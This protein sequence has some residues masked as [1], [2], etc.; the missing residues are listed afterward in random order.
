MERE[1]L[2]ILRNKIYGLYSRPI[3]ILS[4]AKHIISG[5][6]STIFNIAVQEGGF[7]SKLKPVKVIPVYKSGDETEPGNYRP[8]SLLSIFNRIFEKLLYQRLKNFLDKNDTL[9]KSQYGFREK[10][11]TQHAAIDIVDIIQNNMD[12]KLFTCGIFLDLKKG[13]RYRQSFNLTKKSLIT[14]VSEASLMTGFLRS[15]LAVHK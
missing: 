9:F 15:S 7:P 8:I 14:M 13:L 1:I 12:L 4:G 11:S 6:L 3:H 2:S 10:H 5:P